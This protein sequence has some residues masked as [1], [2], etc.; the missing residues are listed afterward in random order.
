MTSAARHAKCAVMS[1]ALETAHLTRRF[2]NALALDDVSFTIPQG[3]AVALLGPNGAGKTTLLRLCAT[4][5]RPSHGSI[6]IFDADAR[7]QGSAA[8]RRIALLSH[9]SFLY[10]DLTPTENLLFYA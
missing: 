9:D 1:V 3:A 10:T 5:L 6:R 7:N 2:G 8:R 4:I